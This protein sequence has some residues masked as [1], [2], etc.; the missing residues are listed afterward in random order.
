M[1]TAVIFTITK[2]STGQIIAQSPSHKLELDL[3]TQRTR[4]NKK[5]QR[6]SENETV[7]SLIY[8]PNDAVQ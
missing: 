3:K 7:F 2:P 8:I 6:E 4:K 1:L 5:E